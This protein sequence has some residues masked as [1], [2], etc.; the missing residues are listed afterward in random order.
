[1]G[2]YPSDKVPQLTK[3][4]SQAI[5]EENTGSRLLNWIKITTLLILWV[6]RDQ[7]TPF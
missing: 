5:I 6:E 2:S 3:T 1:M 4:Q 7:L